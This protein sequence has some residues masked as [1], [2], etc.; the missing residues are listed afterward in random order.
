MLMLHDAYDNQPNE[1]LH[2]S[3][4]VYTPIFGSVIQQQIY[5]LSTTIISYMGFPRSALI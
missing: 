5:H 1:T 2:I 4:L 3:V